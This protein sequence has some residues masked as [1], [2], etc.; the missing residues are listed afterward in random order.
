MYRSPNWGQRDRAP[1]TRLRCLDLQ[2]SK[3]VSSLM[4]LLKG[5]DM[6]KISRGEQNEAEGRK[7]GTKEME[8]SHH[9][10]P[11]VTWLQQKPSSRQQSLKEIMASEPLRR[12]H[13]WL[14]EWGAKPGRRGSRQLLM[15]GRARRS[16]SGRLGSALLKHHLSRAHSALQTLVWW[17]SGRSPG[18]CILTKFPSSTWTEKF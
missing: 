16:R 5:S 7:T 1:D 11:S 3:K 2:V 13:P 17:V 15:K 4:G 12:K 6:I 14:G 18:I 10:D 8:T 9:N